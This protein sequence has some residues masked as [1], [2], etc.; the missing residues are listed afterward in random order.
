[1]TI[2][3]IVW[4]C[5][6]DEKSSLAARYGSVAGLAELGVDVSWFV[7]VLKVLVNGACDAASHVFSQHIERFM[8]QTMS[9]ILLHVWVGCKRGMR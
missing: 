1:M 3:A 4:Q 6:H 5:L 9:R 7:I 8:Y 2:L